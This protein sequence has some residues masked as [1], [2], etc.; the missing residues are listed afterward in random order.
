[1]CRSR[2]G[3]INPGGE[4]FYQKLSNQAFNHVMLH[5]ISECKWDE[6]SMTVTSPTLQSKLLTVIE[7][8][9]QDWVKKLAQADTNPPKKIVNPNAAFPFQDDFSVSKSPALNGTRPKAIAACTAAAEAK[10]VT[11]DSRCDDVRTNERSPPDNRQRYDGGW[12]TRS[13]TN[14]HDDGSKGGSPRLPQRR[15]AHERTIAA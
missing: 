13:E 7:F 15:R 6:K 9:N 12:R 2:P 14:A 4:R 3:V 1:M 8:K 11:P 10:A 5:N